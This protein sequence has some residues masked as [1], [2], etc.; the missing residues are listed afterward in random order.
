MRLDGPIDTEAS[1]SESEKHAQEECEARVVGC[2]CDRLACKLNYLMILQHM[3]CVRWEQINAY[4]CMMAMP[5]CMAPA[6]I[7]HTHPA[8]NRTHQTQDSTASAAVLSNAGGHSSCCNPTHMRSRAALTEHRTAQ[9]LLQSCQMQ[10]HT[11]PAAIQH[12]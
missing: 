7:Q 1:T 9:L 12:T 2:C 10:G 5:V 3:Q 8:L 4:M 11:A 6:A